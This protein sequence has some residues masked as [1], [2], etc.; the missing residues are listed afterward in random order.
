MVF[1]KEVTDFT[2]H[3]FAGWGRFYSLYYAAQATNLPANELVNRVFSCPWSGFI[4]LDTNAVQAKERFKAYI[5]KTITLRERH[6]PLT[7]QLSVP[8]TT[9]K[10]E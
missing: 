4:P 7:E 1:G 5:E 10:D 3:K 8:P 2:K 6:R 9:V